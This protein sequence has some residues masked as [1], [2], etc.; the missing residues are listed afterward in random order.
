MSTAMAAVTV[1]FSPHRE[2]NGTVLDHQLHAKA[3]E[4]SLLVLN[5]NYLVPLTTK[6]LSGFSIFRLDSRL[7][8]EASRGASR[9]AGLDVETR[10]TIAKPVLY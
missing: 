6:T 1:M 7:S 9:A 10:Q 3:A 8:I 4:R 5:R 2:I